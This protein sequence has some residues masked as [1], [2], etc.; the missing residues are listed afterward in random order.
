MKKVDFF[1][2]KNHK[3]WEMLLMFLFMCVCIYI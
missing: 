3:F 2:R 1:S